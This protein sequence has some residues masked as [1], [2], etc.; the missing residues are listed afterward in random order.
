MEDDHANFGLLHMPQ[1]DGESCGIIEYL[2]LQSIPDNSQVVHDEVKGEFQTLVMDESAGISDEVLSQVNLDKIEADNVLEEDEK[3]ND[4]SNIDVDK[5]VDNEL[6]P[7]DNPDCVLPAVSE[8]QTEEYATKT[9]SDASIRKARWAIHIFEQWQ[10]IC[11]FNTNHTGDP[12]K[13]I[14]TGT[15]LDMSD[16]YLC[17][18]LC[19]FVMEIKKQN[20]QLYPKETLYEIVLVLQ[21][22]L[23]MSGHSVKF[24][25]NG[26]FKQLWNTLDNQMKQLSKIGAVHPKEQADP[27]EI[28]EEEL[29]WNKGILG[30]DTPEKLVNTVLYLFRVHFALRAVDEHKSLHTGVYSQLKVCFDHKLESKYLEYKE[31]CAKNNQGGIKSLNKKPKVVH[32]YENKTKPDRCIIRLYEKYLAKHPSHDIKCSHDF[33][34]HPLANPKNPHV[35]YSYQPTGIHPLGKII[36]KMCKA[37]GIGGRHTNHS[38]RSTAATRMYQY[39]LEEH[40][41]AQ[42]TG[43]ASVAVHLYKRTSDEQKQNISE[44]LYAN[45]TPKQDNCAIVTPVKNLG[46]QDS[47]VNIEPPET[48]EQSNPI[49]QQVFVNTTPVNSPQVLM[50]SLPAATP[51][52]QHQTVT[53]LQFVV[54]QPRITVHPVINL[55]ASDLMMSNN[56]VQIPPIDVHLTIN[57][58]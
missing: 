11:N 26:K 32:A 46:D 16:E 1:K 56:T 58:Q 5:I 19:K 12:G 28:S 35:W 40:Q 29:M 31:H 33:Y 47:S 48:L 27:I 4:F 43:H 36:G 9:Y 15:L 25:E 8:E 39:G 49:Q 57:I 13:H 10:Q 42:V 22:H 23:E 3:Q 52:Q 54:N 44:V 34:L 51:L 30:D 21:S 38:L 55:R 50:T 20:S 7:G 17:L 2:D 45:K 24:L 53:V 6:H 41:V 18:T 14:I 37:A